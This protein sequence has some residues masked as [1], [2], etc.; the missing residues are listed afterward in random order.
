MPRPCLIVHGGAGFV[1]DALV[2]VSIAGCREA[3]ATGLVILDRGGTAIDAV[4]A[5][6]RSL[7]D[8]PNFNAGRG[9][10]LNAEGQ[11][12]MDAAIMNGDLSAG[13]VGCVRRVANP[14]TLARRVMERTRHV[15]LVGP[16]ADRFAASQGL[17]LASP[18][19]LVTPRQLARWKSAEAVS[20][21]EARDGNT[22]GAVAVDLSGHVAAGTSTGGLFRKM[23]GRVGDTPVFGAGTFADDRSGAASATGVGEDIIR[24]TLART[25]LAFL[26]SGA[27]ASAAARRATDVLAERTRGTGGI[28]LVTPAGDIGI[29]FNSPR[30]S[31]AYRGANGAVVAS[32]GPT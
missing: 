3:C 28:I 17:D 26:E 21:S 4:E 12:E 32:V 25:A 5:A 23:P 9:A 18:D 30:M 19:S 31:H 14:I 11:I 8:N 1:D 29:A 24:V 22:V 2:E 20:T 16:A 15:F 13:A 10:V 7:E 6:V 27:S